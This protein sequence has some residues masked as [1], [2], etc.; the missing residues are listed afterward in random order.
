MIIIL[1]THIV[2]D[3]IWYL[4]IISGL[5]ILMGITFNNNPKDIHP[6]DSRVVFNLNKRNIIF[7]Q[8]Y[9]ELFVQKYFSFYLE[10]DLC[11]VYEGMN[12]WR[13]ECLVE[14]I[15]QLRSITFHF[16]NNIKIKTNYNDLFEEDMLDMDNQI[17]NI[18]FSKSAHFIEFGSNI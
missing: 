3:V 1:I 5:V 4:L 6:I 16:R 14:I 7:P 17:F 9:R 10:K 2:Q 13:I 12:G 18:I 8:I 11:K 15:K